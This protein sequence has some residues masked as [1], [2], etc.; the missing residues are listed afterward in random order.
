ML[1]RLDATIVA[2]SSAPGHGAVGIV[3]LSGPHAIA[4][5]AD[6]VKVPGDVPLGS[7]PGSTRTNG[8]VRPAADIELPAVFYIFQA[9][10]SYTRQDLVEIHSIGSPAVL[11]MIRRRAMA[12]GAVAA[13]PG[14]FTARAFLNGA[15]DLA[16]A[17]AVAGVIRAQSDT[18][19]RAS[20]R[21]MDGRLAHIISDVRDE[22]AELLALVEADIDFAEEPIEFITPTDLRDRLAAIAV[23]L[24]R[25]SSEAKSTER[26]DQLP[27]ILLLGR[28]NAGKSSL[29]NILSGTSRAICAA[30]AGTTRDILSAP[31]RLGR[32]E[33][34]LLDAAGVDQADDDIIAQAR[35]LT[36]DTAQQV[37][38]VCLV[39]DL[40]A[41]E[42][43]A[44]LELV[45]T[46]G[47]V[48]VVVAANKCDLLS[49]TE[50]AHRIQRMEAWNV[51]PVQG[52]S[53]RTGAGIEALRAAWLEALG[54]DAGTTLGEAMLLS[55]RQ[56]SVI[57]DACEAIQRAMK[58]SESAAE[59]VDCAD[60]A[61]FELREALDALGSVSGAVTT[62]DLLARVFANFCI[63]K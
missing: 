1:D 58:L 50:V 14:E 31:I 16:E 61:A 41:A 17:E 63:G 49:A 40:S 35:M 30:A 37:D 27:R 13:Q 21:M 32:G 5:T 46:L 4:I 45:R 22:L 43:D 53:A 25:L 51:G 2:V 44:A 54:D 15:M 20:R 36:L 47:L 55:E 56:R 18:Q 19:L 28:P 24:S 52:V 38:L 29:M 57:A 26:F 23:R 11:E 3:R 59:T 12:L 8:E 33:A 6:M 62:D 42:D 9:P 48:R 34:I 60:L 10:R 7:R 39:V